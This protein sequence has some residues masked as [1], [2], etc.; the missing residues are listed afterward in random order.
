MEQRERRVIENPRGVGKLKKGN[1]IIAT[2]S[3]DLKVIENTLIADAWGSHHRLEGQGEIKGTF[4]IIDEQDKVKTDETYTLQLSD[5]REI[6]IMTP[7]SL[8]PNTEIKIFLKNAD[9]FYTIK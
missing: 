5:G 8:F 3:Y 6:E 9:K 7:Q 4:R 1:E 2:V